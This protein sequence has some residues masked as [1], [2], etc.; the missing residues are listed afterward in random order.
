MSKRRNEENAVGEDAFLD[1]IANLVGRVCE[2]IF[3]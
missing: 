1:T 3:I 2:F